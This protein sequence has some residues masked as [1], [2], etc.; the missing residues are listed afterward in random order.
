MTEAH[1]AHARILVLDLLHELADFFDA[2][3]GLQVFQH[4]QACLVGPAVGRP[5]QAPHPRRNGRKRIGARRTA[6]ANGRTE[7][8][9]SELQSLMRP[10][11]AVFCLKKKKKYIKQPPLLPNTTTRNN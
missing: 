7:E 1:Q 9:T 10:S 3:V 6:Q 5:P 8:H 2:A 11:Y 4:L